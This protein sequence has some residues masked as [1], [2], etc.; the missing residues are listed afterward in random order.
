MILY[1]MSQQSLLPGSVFTDFTF[2]R[3]RTT[4]SQYM[5]VI[6]LAALS[7]KQT[8]PAR[9]DVSLAGVCLNVIIIQ[10]SVIEYSLADSTC[11]V[12]YSTVRFGFR[13]AWFTDGKFVTDDINLRFDA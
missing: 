11:D 8:M 6:D 2:E 7:Y 12:V 1:M 4:V 13:F 5:C 9:V 3:Q 10:V